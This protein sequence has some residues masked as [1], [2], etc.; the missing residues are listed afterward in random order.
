MVSFPGSESDSVRGG[1]VPLAMSGESSDTRL[2]MKGTETKTPRCIALD[3]FIGTQVACRIYL[4]RP[5]TCRA[6]RR[7]W[8]Q[9]D[10]NFLCDRAR[11]A[12]GLDPFSQ[13]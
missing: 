11:S 7:S 4:N 9:G 10:G 6:F 2:Y 5:S 3:G 8:E 12:F 13:Y 1:V